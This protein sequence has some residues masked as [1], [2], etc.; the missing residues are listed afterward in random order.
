MALHTRASPAKAP[1]WAAAAAALAGVG[2]ALS[3]TTG[4]RASRAAEFGA[5]ANAFQIC[6]D[7]LGPRVVDERPHEIGDVEHDLVAGAD[8]VSK[9]AAISLRER[10]RH[11]REAAA[12]TDH[13]NVAGC[14]TIETQHHRGEAGCHGRVRIDDSDTIRARHREVGLAADRSQFLLS[15][16]PG[17]AALH[18]SACPHDAGLDPGRR[19]FAHETSDGRSRNCQDRKIRRRRQIRDAGE[20]WQAADRFAAAIDGINHARGLKLAEEAHRRTADIAGLIRGA[21]H[22]DG[23]RRQQPGNIC[24]ARERRLR[25][26]IRTHVSAPQISRGRC[27]AAPTL[28]ILKCFNNPFCDAGAIRICVTRPRL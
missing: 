25:R 9:A 12:L 11:R 19:A 14:E 16:E 13:R 20:T 1:V 15:G 21:D 2:P 27:S 4:L 22:G 6:R 10:Q 26:I 18:E 8:H 24:K 17:G 5:V 23:A 28:R 3:T 7:H